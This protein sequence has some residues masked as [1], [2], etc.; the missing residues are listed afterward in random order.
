MQVVEPSF[1]IGGHLRPG[2]SDEYGQQARR[3]GAAGILRERMFGAGRLDPVLSGAILDHFA[4]VELRPN[5]TLQHID[6]D[7][8]ITPA[9]DLMESTPISSSP[10]ETAFGGWT[11]G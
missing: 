6:E 11:V 5:S 3:H 8:L 4:V 7:R 1:I 2:W 10:I 9:E